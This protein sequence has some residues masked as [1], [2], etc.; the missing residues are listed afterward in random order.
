[1]RLRRFLLSALLGA[2]LSHLAA[3]QPARVGRL[4][5][6]EAFPSYARCTAVNDRIFNVRDT[7]RHRMTS[8]AVDG[9]RRLFM[10]TSMMSTQE[11]RRTEG[12]SVTAWFSEDGVVKRGS[13]LAFTT[14]TPARTKDDVRTGLLPGDTAAVAKL[15][16]SLRKLCHL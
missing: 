15:V 1:M 9:E 8:V 12:E 16:A 11:A 13:R 7:V 6:L 4:P 10:F 5:L 2:G 3:A 14:G